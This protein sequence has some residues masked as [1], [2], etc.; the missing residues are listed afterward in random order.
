MYIVIVGE[1][2]GRAGEL[3]LALHDFGLDWTVCWLTDTGDAMTLPSD[4]RI[5]GVVSDMQV[6]AMAGS[7]LLEQVRTLHPEA[8]R[9]L[10]L[11][12]SQGT[13]ATRVLDVAHRFLRKPLDASE[14][15]EAVESVQELRDLL[16]NP[17][18]VQ[19]IGRIG[20]L[21]PPPKLHV[22]LRRR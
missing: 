12:R 8:A 14:L 2:G 22:E 6:G 7:E 3:Q 17:T 19:T 11:E 1:E 15:I 20:S 16:T 13:D 4:R 21:P 18:L 10:L 5:D 9:I